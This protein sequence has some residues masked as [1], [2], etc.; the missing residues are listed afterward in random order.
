MDAKKRQVRARSMEYKI[1]DI[2]R[3]YGF[4]ADRVPLS[5]SANMLKGDVA[6]IKN[7]PFKAFKCLRLLIDN[8]S[9]ISPNIRV[10]R[11]WLD[12]LHKNARI[13]HQQ[14]VAVLPVLTL[15]IPRHKVLAL[16]PAGFLELCSTVITNAIFR[17]VYK[18]SVVID[19]TTPPTCFL[20]YATDN[21]SCW[22]LIELNVLLDILWR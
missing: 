9:T 17:P 13:L 12:T 19:K 11:E 15:T 21:V 4:K 22:R 14:Y 20:F 5:G 7:E 3:Q 2:C 6:A 16:V 8:K 1:R 10:E 18:N